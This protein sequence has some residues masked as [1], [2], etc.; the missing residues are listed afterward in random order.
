MSKSRIIIVGD[1]KARALGDEISG[2]IECQNRYDVEIVT[3]RSSDQIAWK[4][5]PDLIIVLVPVCNEN[6]AS[7][8]SSLRAKNADTPVLPVLRPDELNSMLTAASTDILDFVV[9]PL[10]PAEVLVRIERLLSW[11]I[12][13]EPGEPGKELAQSFELDRLVGN[14]PIFTALKRKLPL[15]ARHGAPVLL[16]GETGTGKELCAR[17]IH[18]L[19]PRVD[20]PFLPVNCG[21]IPPELFESELFGHQRG[22]FTGAW[23]PQTGLVEE[24]EGGTLFLDE[25]ESLSLA[26]QVKLLRF[27]EELTYHA[28]GS[29]KA[30][31]ADVRII[32]ATNVD[33]REKIRGGAF[34]EDLFYRLA[35]MNVSLPPLRARQADIPLL[36]EFFWSRYADLRAGRKR[37]LS[38]R[39]MDAL[40]QYA[41]PGNVRE[42]ENV[43]QQLLVL[44]DIEIIEPDD[45]PVSL[46]VSLKRSP[47]LSFHQAKA[48]TIAQFEKAYLTEALRAHHGN[49]TRAAKTAKT[50]RRNFGRLIKKYQIG[51]VL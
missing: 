7:V 32:A 1:Q 31:Q 28:V 2:V 24:A 40:Y 50:D 33:L 22:A 41:W 14:A 25:I 51:R 18:Y 35:V 8:L 19:S 17:A 15:V 26:A 9:A 37:R 16:T 21:A 12:E 27:I 5:R 13:K 42:L 47:D 46:P 36:V 49:V 38:P 48:E 3:V 20:K 29:P 6:A 11:S 10:R 4:S 39:A 45:L 23:A 44:T 30:R 43:V 34:R